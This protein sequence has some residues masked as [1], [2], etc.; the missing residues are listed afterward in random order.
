MLTSRESGGV[1]AGVQWIEPNASL[2][3]ECLDIATFARTGSTGKGIGTALFQETRPAAK[4]LGAAW[5]NA[6]IRSDNPSGLAY[7]TRMGFR[8]Y[9]TDPTVTLSDGTVT[10]KTY[11]RFDL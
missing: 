2:P 11:K 6:A 9:K 10:G 1:L 7:Y 3:P 4:S 8:D 5:I